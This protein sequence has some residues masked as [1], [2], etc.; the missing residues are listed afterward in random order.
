MIADIQSLELVSAVNDQE[1]R[2]HFVQDADLLH[3]GGG[4]GTMHF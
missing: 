3:V 2:Y 4:T 1:I